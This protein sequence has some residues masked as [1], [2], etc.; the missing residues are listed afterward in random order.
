[1]DG[2]R[3]PWRS[4]LHHCSVRWSVLLAWYWPARAGVWLCPSRR[5]YA[6]VRWSTFSTAS[7]L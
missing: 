2:L 1:L 3:F 5:F 7:R 4:L 6:Q